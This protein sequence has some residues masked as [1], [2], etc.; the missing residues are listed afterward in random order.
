[1]QMVAL[2]V[3]GLLECHSSHSSLVE[4]LQ[5]TRLT[6][7]RDSIQNTSLNM[8]Q[9]LHEA[10]EAFAWALVM[11]HALHAGEVHTPEP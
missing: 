1:M 2:A 10:R 4:W 9:K 8:P 5:S 7:L 11:Q 6:C 3:L